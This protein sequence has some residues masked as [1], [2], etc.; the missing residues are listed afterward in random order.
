MYRKRLVMVM[1]R[2][3]AVSV[4]VP[5][6]A[7]SIA[8]ADVQAGRAADF[9]DIWGVAGHMGSYDRSNLVADVAYAGIKKW[10]DG[11]GDTSPTSPSN[12]VFQQLFNNGV[13]FI[14]LP[15]YTNGDSIDLNTILNQARYWKSTGALF[16]LEGLNEPGNFPVR[17][18]GVLSSGTD[19]SPIA[20]FQKDYYAAVKADSTLSNTTVITASITGAEGSNVG[21]QFLAIPSPAPSGVLMPA[22][23]KYADGTNQHV[24]PGWSNHAQTIDQNGDYLKSILYGDV[25]QTWKGYVGYSQAQADA[26]PKYVTEGGYAVSGTERPLDLT[27]AGKNNVTAI[28]NAGNEGYQVF[29]LYDFYEESNTPGW[30]L[31][32]GP[33]N[34]RPTATYL[35]NLSVP[36]ADT[37]SN[38]HTFTP[39]S[40]G[41]TFSGLP[42]T[43][44]SMLLQKSNGIFELVVW[45]NINNWDWN[46]N[47]PITINPTNVTV[48]LSTV[49]SSIKVYDI[50][51]GTTPVQT[52]MNTNTF[53]FPLRDYAMVVEIVSTAQ[54][55]LPTATLT[56][57]P[58]SI[59]SGQ[60]STLTWSSDN[61]TSCTGTNF[62]TGNAV[63]GTVTVSPTVT[64]TYSISC[65]GAGGTSTPVS[66]TVTVTT[67]NLP[68]VTITALTYDQTSGDFIITVKNQGGAAT[69]TGIPVGNGIFVDGIQRTWAASS[70]P[71]AAG[72]SVTVSASTGGGVYIIPNGTHTISATVDDVNRFAEL[73]E[74][75]N[76]LTQTI[77]VGGDTTA[78]SV[79]ANLAG[80]AVSSSQINLI[81]AASA[82]NVGV[83]G[84]KI[85]RNGTQIGTTTTNS[86]S[87]TGLTASTVYTYTI[88]AY[89]AVGNN[90]AQA[91][92]INVITFVGAP[93][94]VTVGSRVVTTANLNVR[95]SAGPSGTKRGAQPI[96]SFGTVIGGPTT[97]S[98]HTWW[99]VNYDNAPDGWSIGDY[100][101]VAAPTSSPA[102]GM[103]ASA[104][105]ASTQS[106]S[107]N[108]SL[109]QHFMRQVQELTR[110]IHTLQSQT[111]GAGTIGQ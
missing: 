2:L 103:S 49:A 61:A 11:M 91:G 69:P 98:R 58:A 10:R 73:D 43:G 102:L 53:T 3:F 28:L 96:G 14:A 47:T 36:I 35:H 48:N 72:A 95:A 104:S 8:H 44:A 18:N 16:A 50:T 99:N 86:Y 68:D 56:A 80:T 94:V 87:N 51:S 31:F 29:S 24:Y 4:V 34:P 109:I 77:T 21:L 57:T 65:T 111:A 59:T 63:S 79:P 20:N 55:P 88:S 82:D 9:Q 17:Y 32:A 110:Q 78:P 97:A 33:G 93:Q 19:W 42:S 37:A 100:L 66:A 54:N 45:N 40:L 83:T 90:S 30:G 27:T 6:L 92:G 60:S 74:T 108:S 25:S 15:W 84:Y 67:G 1:R 105:F 70:V 12:V 23:T 22:G 75:N 106:T 39:G 13:K 71:L 41:Y 107:L 26:L 7:V 62:S 38:A 89:D 101:A 5:L 76:T 81:W 46:S 64:T 52:L 85:F